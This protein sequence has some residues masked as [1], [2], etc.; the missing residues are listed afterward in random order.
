MG[1]N[2]GSAEGIRRKFPRLTS[3]LLD[4]DGRLWTSLDGSRAGFE[5]GRKFL[6][7]RALETAATHDTPGNTPLRRR[8][9]SA[10]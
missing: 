10:C 7:E 4:L 9:N 6:S 5:V 2:Q 8:C 1:S 3:K